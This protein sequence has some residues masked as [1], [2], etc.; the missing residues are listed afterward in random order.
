M[1]KLGTSKRASS[2]N[3]SKK[4]TPV[5]TPT[6]QKKN[7]SKKSTPAKEESKDSIPTKRISNALEQLT[8]YT[9]EAKA[10]GDDKKSLLDDDDE[11]NKSLS[12]IVV[13]N[14]SFSGPVKNFKL[15][16][17]DVDHSLYV[18]WKEASAT[19]VKDFKTLLILKDSDNDKV[20]EDDLYDSLNESSITI[21]EIIT[22]NQ[23]K[24][25]YKAFE[26][27]R[28]FVSQFSLILAD[29]SIV[30]SLPKL[31]GSKAYSK[32]ETTPVP[33]RTYSNKE[34][35][36]V[37]LV[38]S[39]KKV[40]LHQLPVKIPRG[41]TMNVHLGNLEWFKPE[42]LVKNVDSI[43]KKLIDLYSIR[44]IFIKSNQSPV[45]PLY[46][47]NDVIAELAAAKKDAVA[48]ERESIKIDGVEVQLSNFDKALMEIANPKE[49]TNLFA[50]QISDAKRSIDDSDDKVDKK[51][52]KKAKN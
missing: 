41:T 21:D 4:S 20:S 17:F 34:F 14:K 45:L 6:K 33:I 24:T 46:Y 25:T 5:N 18:P 12:L 42:A 9:T 22:G 30:T 44:S 49:L 19:S 23:L 26:T 27:R 40:Y 51:Q 28:A 7:N 31:L 39:I 43:T 2:K 47:N 35:S 8:K 38:N 16:L 13:N 50:K 1:A 37:T 32:L 10:K 15:K 11:L 29:D 48:H 52:I 36:K 3:S